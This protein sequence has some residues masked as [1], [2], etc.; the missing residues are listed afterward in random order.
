MRRDLPAQVD[1]VGQYP[2]SHPRAQATLRDDVDVA[3]QQVLE[4]HQQAAE[5]EQAPV[6]FEVDQEVH[7]ACLGG[8]ATRH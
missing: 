8:L 5:V 7:V 6:W 4:I 3:L 2:L 1:G